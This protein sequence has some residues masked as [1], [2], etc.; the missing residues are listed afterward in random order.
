MRKTTGRKVHLS[1]AVQRLLH[2][3]G[4]ATKVSHASKASHASQASKASHATNAPSTSA[5]VTTSGDDGSHL[6]NELMTEMGFCRDSDPE[7]FET[8]R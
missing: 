6:W 4:I 7:M 3:G 1:P 8:E 5:C 2:R